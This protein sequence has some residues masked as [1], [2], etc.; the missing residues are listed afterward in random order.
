MLNSFFSQDLSS[1]PH[2][3][4]PWGT[5]PWLVFG[6]G[7]QSDVDVF[8]GLRPEERAGEAD[9][10]SR[11]APPSAP[12]ANIGPTAIPKDG[13][14]S[15]NVFRASFPFRMLANGEHMWWKMC[16][17]PRSATILSSCLSMH[18]CLPFACGRSEGRADI[19]GPYLRLW[20]IKRGEGTGHHPRRM[21]DIR[22]LEKK[23]SG[24]KNWGKE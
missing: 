10:E 24:W 11:F 5:E 19:C 23:S 17:L 14:P 16:C 13:R 3:S 18:A 15:R 21:R 2:G 4:S 20:K 22:E 8:A 6:T 9:A 7:P 1:V 12:S